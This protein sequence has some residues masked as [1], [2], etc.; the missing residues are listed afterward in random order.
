MFW[1]LAPFEFRIRPKLPIL[2]ISY[3]F[4]R[5]VPKKILW[6]H[7]YCLIIIF[8]AQNC[9]FRTL[10]SSIYS[11]SGQSSKKLLPIRHS[12]PCELLISLIH[13]FV[14]IPALL[15]KNTLRFLIRAGILT[16]VWIGV[17]PIMAFIPFPLT[18]YFIKTSKTPF[19]AYSW[20]FLASEAKLKNALIQ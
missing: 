4:Q 5:I 9:K 16:K 10:F 7:L 3:C 14:D 19:S 8:Y 15:L 11:K 20:Q 6:W 17:I 18:N 13:H 2:T 12:R 1:S